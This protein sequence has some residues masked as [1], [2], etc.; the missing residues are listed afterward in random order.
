[1]TA[2]T[3][4]STGAT[5]A[6]ET[7]AVRALR[8]VDE[9]AYLER[10]TAP[11]R[12]GLLGNSPWAVAF[13]WGVGAAFFAAGVLWPGARVAFVVAFVVVSLTLVAVAVRQSHRREPSDGSTTPAPRSAAITTSR[14]SR[15]S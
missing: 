15:S 12:P 5:A 1:M 14:V 10:G 4:G 11:R 6:R 13:W 7:D 2:G 8:P 3:H 9:H